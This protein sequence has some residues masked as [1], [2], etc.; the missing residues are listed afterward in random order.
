MAFMILVTGG[1]GFIGRNLIK[2]LVESGHKVRILLKPSTTSPNFPKGIAVEVAVSSLSD[3]RG[4]RAALKDV[5]Q[6]FHLAG[7]ERK[8]SR[9]DLNQVDVEGTSTIMQAAKEAKIERVYYLSHHGAARA[10]AYPV[11]KAK[12]IAEHWIINSGIPYTIVRTGSIFGPG[13][14]FTVSLAKLIKIS[15]FFLMPSKGHV[16]LQPLWIDDL[17]N[18]L[19]L[20]MEDPKAVNRIYSIGGMEPLPYREIVRLI[21]NKTGLKRYIIPISPATLRVITL[22]IDQIFPSFPVS[23]FWLDHLAEDRTANLD[24][25]PREFGIMPA[26]FHQHLDYLNTEIPKRK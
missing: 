24:S 21:M 20:V 3:Q 2:A 18:V 10:S 19:L 11:L 12:A 25:L 4:V 16:L 1:T 17:I 23:I 15:P 5:T 26:R 7:A 22:W 13:D 9:G 6:I 14:Q 8:G